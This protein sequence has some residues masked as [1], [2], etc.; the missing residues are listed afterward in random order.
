MLL[1]DPETLLGKW[2]KIS[3]NEARWFFVQQVRRDGAITWLT[4]EA[5]KGGKKRE[6][7]LSDVVDQCEEPSSS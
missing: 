5:E 7:T 2:V 4:V 1:M 6:C 3:H